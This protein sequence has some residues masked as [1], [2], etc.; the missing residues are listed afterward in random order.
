MR[1][2]VLITM[3]DPNGVGP[4]ICVK[5]ALASAGKSFAIIGSA[6]VLNQAA[7]NCNL[8][9]NIKEVPSL[10]S[11][12]DLS[13]EFG[14]GPL[15]LVMAP[16]G[17]E[18]TAEE[19]HP[20]QVCPRAGAFSLACVKTA[21]DLL[22]RKEAGAMVTGP[23]NK[24]AI[25]KTVPGFQ[26]HTEFIGEMC[27]DPEPVLT[28]VHGNNWV[29]SHVSTHVS[30]LE[31]VQRVRQARIIKTAKLL[32]EFLCRIK[33]KQSC[34]IGVA[35]LNPHAGENGLF[36][37]EEQEEISPAIQK[38]QKEGIDIHGPIPGDV[39]FP[40]MK[41]GTWEGVV[42]MYHDQ[43]HVVTKTLGFSLGEDRKL[44]GVNITLGLPVIRTS[45]DHGTGFDI[46]WKNQ[47]D[48]SSLLDAW[49][50]ALRLI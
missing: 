31:A 34:R 18:F 43:G 26:G 36:G 38:L 19:L 48:C 5:A 7:K 10:E 9:L 21:V 1:T 14:K 20:G 32:H 22:Q 45:V 44:N 24:E 46:A 35:G 28:L 13:A 25:D 50:I 12:P 47:A 42:A 40:Q 29:I 17:V 11:I 37:T 33:D 49:D 8:T 30:M 41:A 16:T 3:G 4:E 23:I 39:V 2:D 27:G 15:V 6:S